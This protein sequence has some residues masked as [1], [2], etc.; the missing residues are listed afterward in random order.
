MKTI[1][2]NGKK[3]LTL[4]KMGLAY[5]VREIS[6]KRREINHKMQLLYI[7]TFKYFQKL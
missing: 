4:V 6:W 1:R 5:S 2:I 3:G 7:Q